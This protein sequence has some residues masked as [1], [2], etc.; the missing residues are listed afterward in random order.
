MAEKTPEGVA[1]ELFDK[2]A[3]SERMVFH[4]GG[5]E[6][7]TIADRAWILDTYAECLLATQGQRVGI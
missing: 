2:I 4:S 5:G 3:G 1:L 6:G 7:Y